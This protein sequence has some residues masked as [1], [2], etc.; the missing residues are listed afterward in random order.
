MIDD[1]VFEE[2]VPDAALALHGWPGIGTDCV[3]A[4]PKTMM[5]SCDVINITVTGKGGHG[6]RPELANNPLLGIARIIEALSAL[7]GTE[8]VVSICAARVGKQANVIANRG[9]LSGTIRALNEDI[10]QA[11]IAEIKSLVSQACQ[12]LGLKTEINFDAMSPAV[13]NNDH[14]YGVFGDVARRMLGSEK[15][16]TLEEPS[17]GSED[18]GS[19]L[20]HVPGLLFRVGTGTDCA[21]LHQGQFDFSDEALRTGMLVLSGLAFRICSEGM[22]Q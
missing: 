13:I 1:G 20:Q 9:R 4:R 19:Y 14:L 6:A 17:M 7:D 12:P 2:Q 22:P 15:V 8:R 5:A 18:F 21:Q 3:A 16:L 11:T 10:R